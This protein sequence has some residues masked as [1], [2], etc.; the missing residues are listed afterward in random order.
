MM[1]LKLCQLIGDRLSVNCTSKMSL[2]GAYHV[3]RK[4]PLV[5]MTLPMSGSGLTTTANAF[6]ALKGGTPPAVTTVVS[7]LLVPDCA[8]S[9]VHVIT[10]VFV[11]ITGWFVPPTVLVSTYVSTGA[12]TAASL[13]VFVTTSRF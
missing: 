9:G 13:A 3:S 12:G 2:V 10:P 4:P 1:L 6:V 8:K 5:W 7:T 11:L